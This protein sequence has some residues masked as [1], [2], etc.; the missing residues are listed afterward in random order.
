MDTLHLFFVLF[1]ISP[2]P[3]LGPLLTVQV[4]VV[5]ALGDSINETFF[6]PQPR[7]PARLQYPHYDW[8]KFGK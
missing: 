8:L 6:F 7:N 2:L 4:F 1:I 5:L 3:H